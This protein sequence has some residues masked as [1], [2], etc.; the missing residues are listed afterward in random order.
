MTT[1]YSEAFFKQFFDTV[2]EAFVNSPNAWNTDMADRTAAW[3]EQTGRLY[4]QWMEICLNAAGNFLKDED[5]QGDLKNRRDRNAE[6]YTALYNEILGRYLRI[7]RIGLGGQSFQEMLGAMDAYHLLMGSL[8]EFLQAF[9]LPFAAS[10][11]TFQHTF[12]KKKDA[13][14][15]PKDLYDAFLEIVDQKYETYLTSPEGVRDVTTLVDRYLEYKKRLDTAIAPLLAFHN[16]PTKDEMEEVYKRLNSLRKKNRKLEA[17]TRKQG[18]M[19]DA[20]GKDIIALKK[21]SPKKG[22][23]TVSPGRKSGRKKKTGAV[24]SKKSGSGSTQ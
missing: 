5:Q 14:E 21:L 7:P 11:E 2:K 17:V 9:A 8:N 1:Q 16:I 15:N 12:G 10:L 6:Q 18:K 4:S 24:T 23:A 19:I 22:A 13:F 3:G 20:L